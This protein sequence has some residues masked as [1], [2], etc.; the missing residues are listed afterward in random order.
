MQSGEQ[1]G[2]AKL[3]LFAA[4]YRERCIDFGAEPSVKYWSRESVSHGKAMWIITNKRQNCYKVKRR[5]MRLACSALLRKPNAC[6]A[7]KPIGWLC[8]INHTEKIAIR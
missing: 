1:P 2:C 7:E 6:S 5:Q 8:G 4:D 3:L